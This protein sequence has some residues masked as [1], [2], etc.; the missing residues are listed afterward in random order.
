MAPT[1][2]VH[3]IDEQDSKGRIDGHVCPIAA[4]QSA[5]EEQRIS[6]DR[7]RVQGGPISIWLAA[8]SSLQNCAC[9]R[10]RS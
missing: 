1:A 10:D 9:S 8:N 7:R 5:R 2:D 3:Y 4:A 6:F